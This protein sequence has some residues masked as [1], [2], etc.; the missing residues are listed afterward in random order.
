MNLVRDDPSARLIGRVCR[1]AI[2]S[3]RPALDIDIA[4]GVWDLDMVVDKLLVNRAVQGIDGP[5]AKLGILDPAQ[6]LK[7]QGG[8]SEIAKAHP[9]LGFAAYLVI[10]FRDVH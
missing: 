1:P 8:R 5:A 9:V 3:L 7:L 4:L 6:E 10:G 2:R